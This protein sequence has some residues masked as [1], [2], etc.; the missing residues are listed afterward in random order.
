[1]GLWLALVL[2]A[3]VYLQSVLGS[4]YYATNVLGGGRYGAAAILGAVPLLSLAGLA[5]LIVVSRK[6]RTPFRRL[7]AYLAL[8]LWAA[9]VMSFLA[10]ILY[11]A[12]KALLGR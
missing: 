5:V 2:G 4:L 11:L 12:P 8:F 6:K 3:L 10:A 1:M 7:I 9:G